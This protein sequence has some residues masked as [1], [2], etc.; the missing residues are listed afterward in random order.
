MEYHGQEMR[1]QGR[2]VEARIATGLTSERDAVVLQTARGRYVLQRI[3]GHPFR[4]EVLHG[5]IGRELRC[6]GEL[7]G[8]MFLL[9]KWDVVDDAPPEGKLPPKAARKKAATRKKRKPRGKQK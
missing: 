3:G 1:K 6:E 8:R 7:V 4:D 2:V 5:L 9:K